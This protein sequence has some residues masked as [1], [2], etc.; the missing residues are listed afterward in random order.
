[1]STGEIFDEF[2]EPVEAIS[3]RHRRDAEWSDTHP[4]PRQTLL[5]CPLVIELGD[6]AGVGLAGSLLA[7]LGARVVLVEPALPSSHDKWRH[8]S[9]CAAGKQ[10]IVLDRHCAQDQ[11]LLARLVRS[12]DAILLS[13][14][15]TPE[16]GP[17]WAAARDKKLVVCDVTAFGH[18]GPLAG[19]PC[20][21]ALVEAMAGIV[22]TTGPAD[23]SATPVGTALLETHAA[24]YAAAA[25][26]AAMRVARR[27]GTGQRIDVALFDVAVTSLTNFFALYSAGKAATR[28]GNRHPLFVPW[29]TF[30]TRDGWILICATSDEQWRRVCEV[31]GK[32]DLARDPQFAT[33]S[34]RLD[35]FKLVDRILNDWCAQ[36]TS[37]QC[38]ARMLQAAIAC[39]PIASI[40]NFDTDPNLKHRRSVRSIPDDEIGSTVHVPASPI[41]GFPLGA[42]D[43]ERVPRRDDARAAVLALIQ[44]AAASPADAMITGD[45]HLPSAPLEGI[46]VVEIGQL[47]TAPMA[48]RLMGTLGADVIKIEPPGGDSARRAAPLRSD[49]LSYVFPISNTDKRG[50]VLDLR[51]EQDRESLHRILDNADVLVE[52]LKPGS[53]AKLGFTAQLL[54][55]R[56]PHLIC[57]AVSGFGADS[58]FP[59]RPGLDTVIQGMSGLLNLTLVNG[60]PT[61]TGISASDVL[62]GQFGLLSVLAALEL[63]DRTGQAVHFDLSMQDATVWSTQL[64]WNGQARGPGRAAM[65]RSADGLI[66]VTTDHAAPAE[67]TSKHDTNRT[68]AQLFDGLRPTAYSAPVLTVPEVFAHPQVAARELVLSRPSADGK[69]W[70]VFAT[71]FKLLSTPA[72]VRGVIASL[73]FDHESICAELTSSVTRPVDGVSSPQRTAHSP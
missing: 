63:R 3:H 60:M 28:S 41:R 40:D 61:K 48:C 24:T 37:A 8:R 31:I 19:I 55:Q 44:T 64:E 1:M 17:L 29:G 7:Q 35:N 10:S 14:D 30:A 71:P 72:Q 32:P 73:N 43:A 54:A 23:G 4:E 38:E 2:R 9:V 49:G 25:T 13:S 58:A 27:D 67:S 62:G 66:A 36:H 15:V 26:V 47:T 34:A 65:M 16:D 33:S 56:H 6:R 45:P 68:R 42:V 22:D 18:T 52:N 53:L 70:A 20:A 5:D 59:G 21:E 69:S 12:A 11:A 51:S 46:R 39:G 57:C 50:V